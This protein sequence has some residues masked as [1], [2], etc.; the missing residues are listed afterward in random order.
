MDTTNK[1]KS[2]FAINENNRKNC[3]S[4]T[5][6]FIIMRRGEAARKKNYLP[7]DCKFMSL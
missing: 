4:A 3:K 2:L 1:K 6:D 7:P 5:K